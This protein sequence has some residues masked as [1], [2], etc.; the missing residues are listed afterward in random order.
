MAEP[1][2]FDE[3]EGGVLEGGGYAKDLPVYFDQEDGNVISCWQLTDDE[4]FEVLQTKQVWVVV[5]GLTH[6]PIYVTGEHPFYCGGIKNK[7][8]PD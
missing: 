1:V 2:D 8:D 5:Q 6:P 4:L 3:S 7:P